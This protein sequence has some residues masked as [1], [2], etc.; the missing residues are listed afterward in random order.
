MP[1]TLKVVG[2]LNICKI[3]YQWYKLRFSYYYTINKP[4][5]TMLDFALFLTYEIY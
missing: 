1:K 5:L 2:S 3:Y 4:S